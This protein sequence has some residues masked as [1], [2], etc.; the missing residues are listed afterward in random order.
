MR[1]SAETGG[2]DDYIVHN[3]RG[4]KRPKGGLF[5]REQYPLECPLEQN[6][7]SRRTVKQPASV[8]CIGW[9]L[10]SFTAVC[11][12]M[13]YVN[14]ALYCGHIRRVTI[15]YDQAH[16]GWHTEMLAPSTHSWIAPASGK[17][18]DIY[19]TGYSCLAYVY[20]AYA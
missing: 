6:L 2:M 14:S 10:S 9:C 7:M 3:L 20:H 15:L 5:H 11:L 13:A 4:S 17:T 16:P 18:K 12:S 1:L 8:V 19:A